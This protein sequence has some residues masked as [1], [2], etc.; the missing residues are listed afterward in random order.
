MPIQGKNLSLFG[1]QNYRRVHYDESQVDYLDYDLFTRSF[2]RRAFRL[3]CAEDTL[4][5]EEL[6]KQLLIYEKLYY[7]VKT[8]KKPLI[9]HKPSLKVIGIECRTSNAADKAPVDI[10]RL[11]ERFYVEK[12]F[13]K[14]PDKVSDNIMALY[15]DYEGDFTAPYSLIIG[16]EVRSTDVVP[17]GMTAKIIPEAF[18]AVF[19]AIGEHPQSLI[20][21]WQEIWQT[22]LKRTY[23]G[24]FEVYSKKFVER[25]SKEIEVYIAINEK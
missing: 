9:V 23:S 25:S 1:W 3:L 17:K 7:E 16:C 21:T 14:I 4:K 18:Y 8:M 20:K 12:I 6:L 19:K 2:I 11:W 15:C 10:Q 24:D 22:P 5:T 13:D